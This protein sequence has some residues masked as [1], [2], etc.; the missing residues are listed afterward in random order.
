MTEVMPALEVC[1]EWRWWKSYRYGYECCGNTVYMDLTIVG[2]LWDGFYYDGNPW[3]S[4][5][6]VSK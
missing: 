2:F 5:D 6:R 4:K 1:R 3:S